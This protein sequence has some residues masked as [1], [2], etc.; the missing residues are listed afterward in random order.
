MKDWSCFP[1]LDSEGVLRD[2]CIL[3][4]PIVDEFTLKAD[5]HEFVHAF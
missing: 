3:V 1:I 2:I 5:I 4:P